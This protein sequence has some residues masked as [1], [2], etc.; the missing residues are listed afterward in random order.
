MTKTAG[1][2][3]V[4]GGGGEKVETIK[5]IYTKEMAE[6]FL[7]GQ[8]YK[9]SVSAKPYMIEALKAN[10]LCKE[11]WGNTGNGSGAKQAG[12]GILIALVGI[13]AF[14]AMSKKGIKGSKI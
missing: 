6:T 5:Y 9:A 12:A 14:M 3:S 1:D 10:N 7:Y 8:Y 2:S 13:A 11:I 4:F